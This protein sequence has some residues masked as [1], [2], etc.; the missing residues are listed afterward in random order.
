MPQ[1]YV[2]K[3]SSSAKKTPFV[4]TEM[5]GRLNVKK[6]KPNQGSGDILGVLKTNTN[7]M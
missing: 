2:E 1:K 6:H 5:H 3:G 4:Y 7:L